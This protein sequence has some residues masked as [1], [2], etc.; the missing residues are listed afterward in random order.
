MGDFGEGVELPSFDVLSCETRL[1][2]TQAFRSNIDRIEK[3]L[4]W[5]MKIDVL[6]DLCGR[7]RRC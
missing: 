3:I 6:L 7:R 2:E 1:R 4:T 5:E